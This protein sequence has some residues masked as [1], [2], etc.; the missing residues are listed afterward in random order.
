MRLPEKPKSLV[1]FSCASLLSL[2]GAY[3][4]ARAADAIGAKQAREM[5]QKMAGASLGPDQVQIKKISGG[6]G[7]GVIVEA[8]IETA[9]RFQKDKDGW[10]IVETRLG[11]GQWESFELIEEA[12]KQEKIRRT[13]DLMRQIAVGIGAYKNERGQFVEAEEIAKLL[14]VLTPRYLKTP[15]RFDLWG[16]ELKYHGSAGGYR[17]ISLGPDRK[18]GTKDDLILENGELKTG[19]KK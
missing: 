16:E 10:R 6:V 8:Q 5:I 14:D 4:L 7:G 12:I 13:T 19:E 9:F 3:W 18:S 11:A 2:V 15:H 1:L 17:L